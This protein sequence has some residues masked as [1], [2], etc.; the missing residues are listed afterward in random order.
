VVYYK[1]DEE[2]VYTFTINAEELIKVR[3]QLPFLNDADNF[4]IID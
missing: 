4:E 2:D 1:R 3:A